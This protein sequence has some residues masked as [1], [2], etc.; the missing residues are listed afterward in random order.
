[1]N[2]AGLLNANPSPS[3]EEIEMAM[4]GNICRCGTYTRIKK[5]I[6]T[7]ANS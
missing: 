7:A 1:M 6:K 3:D 2:A 4:H 5:A